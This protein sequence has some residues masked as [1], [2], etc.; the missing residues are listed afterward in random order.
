MS[1]NP[2]V[3]SCIEH[4]LELRLRHSGH[5]RNVIFVF[6]RVKFADQT[7]W[8]TSANSGLLGAIQRF[9]PSDLADHPLFVP[10]RGI[11]DLEVVVSRSAAKRLAQC[12]ILAIRRHSRAFGVHLAS[13][14]LAWFVPAISEEEDVSK[15]GE[16]MEAAR[17]A[18]VPWFITRGISESRR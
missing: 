11:V 12:G 4:V 18:E 14:A 15:L 13:E 5:L 3:E 16:Q 7:G 10:I 1:E 8:S 17:F 6:P 9:K 2:P